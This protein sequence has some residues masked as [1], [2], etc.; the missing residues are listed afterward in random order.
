MREVLLDI[1]SEADIL[2]ILLGSPREFELT[3]EEVSALAQRMG[4]ASAVRAM[5]RLGQMLVE[6]RHAPDPRL[7]LEVALVQLTH[8]AA[9]NNPAFDTVLPGCRTQPHTDSSQKSAAV[10]SNVLQGQVMAPQ[11]DKRVWIWGRFFGA[12]VRFRE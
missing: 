8:E 10:N 1:P 9:S 2:D 12:S 3:A 5:E 4:A 6:M 7:L 11:R